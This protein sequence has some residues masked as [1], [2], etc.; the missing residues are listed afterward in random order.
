MEGQ[1]TKEKRVLHGEWADYISGEQKAS[2]Q[3][4]ETSWEG[5]EAE[6]ELFW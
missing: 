5:V 1:F 6:S 4:A 2:P 3:A